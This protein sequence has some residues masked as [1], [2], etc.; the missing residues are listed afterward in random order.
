MDDRNL[1]CMKI[2]AT[3]PAFMFMRNSY[4]KNISGVHH[5]TFVIVPSF[6]AAETLSTMCK[7]VKQQ[8]LLQPMGQ[9]NV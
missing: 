6:Y 4:D 1:L 5:K 7:N 2:Y 9:T 3:I 8:T